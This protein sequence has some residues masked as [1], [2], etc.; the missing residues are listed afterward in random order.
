VSVAIVKMSKMVESAI[1]EDD[2]QNTSTAI[3]INDANNSTSK[4]V[5]LPNVKANVLVK[6]IDYCTHY[7]TVEEMTPIT[8]P[9]KSPKLEELVQ[10]WYADFCKDLDNDFLFELVTAANYMD[11]KPL[12]DLMCLE[13]AVTIQGN[14][15]PEMRAHFNI[16]KEHVFHQDEDAATG[17]RKHTTESR[18]EMP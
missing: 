16:G 7:K 1:D 9:F 14:T 13:V 12:L 18:E 3:S 8:T 17:S 15:V 4:V 11:I 5:P 10:Q 6:V 2:G